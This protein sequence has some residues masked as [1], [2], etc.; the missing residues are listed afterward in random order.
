MV[1]KISYIILT[2]N[3]E[4]DIAGCLQSLMSAEDIFLLDSF[5][6][7]RTIEEAY[8]V[9]ATH[10]L[11]LRIEQRR[12]RN[13]AEQR[14]SALELVS[15]EWVFFVD[16]DERCSPSL[17]SEIAQRLKGSPSGIAGYWV[18]RRNI[19]LGRE[20]HHAGWYPDYQLRLF[21]RSAGRYDPLRPV[22]EVLLLNGP[23]D[24]L[25]TPLLHYNYRSIREFI[26]KQWNYAKL[27][28][29]QLAQSESLRV[30][31]LA[32]RPLR[33]FWRR[34]WQFEGWRD[35][36]LGF[37]LSLLM[38]WYQFIAVYRAVLFS[39]RRKIGTGD[40]PL[41]SDDRGSPK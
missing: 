5:S 28:A 4:Q 34:Y 20:V 41:V 39:H 38:A 33:E 13:F 1:T 27:D 30:R 8:R 29:H 24:R 11:P 9:A 35:G 25:H 40:L 3:E 23:S 19:I 31:A 7:D 21:Q 17:H 22:H 36:D 32:T 6:T 12:F 2:F 18:P 15:S 26:L 37:V 10:D 16:A 14:N